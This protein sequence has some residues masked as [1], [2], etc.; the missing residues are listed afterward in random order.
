[1][2]ANPDGESIIILTKPCKFY[3]LMKQKLLLCLAILCSASVFA[4]DF[5]IGG[6]YYNYLGGDSVA[7]TYK[8]DNYSEVEYWGEIVIPESVTYANTT[9]RVTEIDGLTF[10]ECTDVTTITIPKSITT[11]G[12]SA[13]SETSLTQTNYTGDIA[14]WCTIDMDSNPIYYSKNLYINNV[15]VTSLIIPD[16]V[17]KI[18]RSAFAHCLS[19]ISVSMPNSVIEIGTDAFAHCTNLKSVTLSNSLKSFSCFEYCT[20]LQEITLYDG[21]E[22]VGGFRGCT[23]LTSVTLPN[24]VKVIKERA[25]NECTALST[26]NTPTHLT[27]IGDWAFYECDNLRTFTIPNSVT[28]IG[29]HAFAS[30]D[31]LSMEGYDNAEYL[32]NSENP[33][34]ALISANSRTKSCTIHENTKVIAGSAFSYSEISS[35]II[36]DNVISIGNSAFE[37]I[38]EL[39]SITWGANLTEI[40]EFAFAWCDGLVEITIPNSVKSIGNSAFYQCHNLRTAILGSGLS[41]LNF[42]LFSNCD[43]LTTVV[44]NEGITTLKSDVFAWCSNLTNISIPNSMISIDDQ[45]FSGCSKLQYNK[46]DHAKYLGNS[47]NPYHVLM[48]CDTTTI[49]S[50]TIHNNTK[51]LQQ[52]AFEDCTQLSSIIIPEGV[53]SID[54]GVFSGCTQLKEVVIPNSVTM[55]GGGV[56]SSCTSLTYVKLPDHLTTIPVSLFSVCSRLETIDIPKNVTKIEDTAFSRCY[57]LTSITIPKKITEIGYGAFNSCYSLQ[58][59]TCLAKIPPTI[60]YVEDEDEMYYGVFYGV[61]RSIPLYVPESSI[62]A[63]STAYDWCEFTNILPAPE[64][65]TSISSIT[66]DDSKTRKVLYNGTIYIV[67]SN[68]ETYTIDGQKIAAM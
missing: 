39:S 27:T 55:L 41:I 49:T 3:S 12:Y 1:M 45:A 4:H 26:I 31:R 2:T 7:V 46:Y 24:T 54:Y 50:C 37:S 17:T 21:V 20:S 62:S 33:Y 53:V 65:A 36:P 29:E 16:G 67:K 13:F 66:V 25:F 9:Y 18:N 61:N 11:I 5:E 40:G 58:D 63:Y 14:S 60:E 6:M 64:D 44:L 23:S 68:G 56:F 35:I 10:R 51:L 28:T 57:S 52:D 38:D 22:E 30:C 15:E 34:H 19:I 59:I 43:S 8:G 42:G 47:T 48:A 32:G